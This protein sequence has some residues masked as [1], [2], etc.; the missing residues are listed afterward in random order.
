MNVDPSLIGIGSVIVLLCL[1]FLR[2]PIAVS[3][4]IVSVVGIWIILGQV[5]ALSI[6][7][8][9]PYSFAASWTLSAVPMFLFMGY[10]AS[11]TGITAGAFRAARAWLAWLPGG[12]AVATAS[13]AGAF[14]AVTGSSVASSAAIGQ[15]ALPEMRKSKYHM[16][17]ACGLVAAGGTLGALIP[18]SLILI[19]FG[20]QAQVS[21]TSLFFGGLIVGLISLAMYV[22]TILCI[23]IMWPNLLPKGEASSAEE[24][25]ASL[26]AILPVVILVIFVFGGLFMGLFTATESGAIGAVLVAVFALVRGELSKSAVSQ[27]VI[28]TL[29]AM[30]SLMM[31]A[32]G[33]MLFSRLAALSGLTSWVVAGVDM[34]GN[35][36]FLILIAISIFYLILGFFLEPIGA[37]LLTLPIILPIVGAAGV[38]VVIFGILLAKLLEVGMITPPVGLN[39]FVV[40]SIAQDYV[41]L[42]QI[43][44]GILVFLLADVILIGALIVYIGWTVLPT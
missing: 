6:L 42:E 9:A 26:L 37:M 2:V 14:A 10:L 27:S 17:I 23:A 20:I 22:M 4:L 43:F 15:I 33:A 5:P 21:I 40:H 39:V 18:P 11:H 7:A 29:L 3:L 25:K 8:N 13:G 34:F 38:D 35:N 24:K 36:T 32:V 19:L 31:I 1:I 28:D 30:G 41:K 12:L 44:K 16:G